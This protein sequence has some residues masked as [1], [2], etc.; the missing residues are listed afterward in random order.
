MWVFAADLLQNVVK[1]NFYIQV[2]NLLQQNAKVILECRFS[3][4]NHAI[5][6]QKPFK[7]L[8][9]Q[10]FVIITPFA[11]YS[12]LCRWSK[13][14]W[15]MDFAPASLCWSKSNWCRSAT[16]C[17]TF[18]GCTT[19]YCGI[20]KP[21]P[22]QYFWRFSQDFFLV[23]IVSCLT[24]DRLEASL[25]WQMLQ[26]YGFSWVCVF[27]CLTSPSFEIKLLVQMLQI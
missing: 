14:V 22:R 17:H 16:I 25:F 27:S 5:S 23:W 18:Y 2:F 11:M 20:P 13:L 1:P 6:R 19:I 10:C 15:S 26:A 8:Q 12:E 7:T 9:P 24:R 21:L 3:W 4:W